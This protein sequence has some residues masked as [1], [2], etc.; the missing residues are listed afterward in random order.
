MEEAFSILHQKMEVI[1]FYETKESDAE[2]IVDCSNDF[3]KLEG[4]L[5]AA[6]EGGPSKII[7]TSQF[8]VIKEG[9][10]FY[11]H[12]RFGHGRAPT[13]LAAYFISKGD[14]AEEAVKKIKPETPMVM[15]SASLI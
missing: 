8:K 11:V 6:G 1:S 15:I 4:N 9:K 2:I 14:T 3:E 10:K 13:M 7:N 5:F 12:C